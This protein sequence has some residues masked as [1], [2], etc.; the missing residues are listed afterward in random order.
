MTDRYPH[1]DELCCLAF[2]CERASRAQTVLAGAAVARAADAMCRARGMRP[3]TQRLSLV[4]RI[5]ALRAPDLAAALA[6]EGVPA[7]NARALAPHVDRALDRDALDALDPDGWMSITS[8]QGVPAAEHGVLLGLGTLVVEAAEALAAP[9]AGANAVMHLEPL[10][11]SPAGPW[12]GV[13]AAGAG[14][15]GMAESEA[16]KFLA[17][18]RDR[19]VVHRT[20]VRAWLPAQGATE[21]TVAVRTPAGL[22]LMFAPFVV[23]DTETLA[24]LDTVGLPDAALPAPVYRLPS[25][26]CQG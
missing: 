10:E 14:L 22:L 8:A 4:A 7:P 12:P 16:R 24:E 17:D 26:P 15:F 25:K 3:R 11:R 18:V 5:S 20:G 1:G 21:T 2:V 23:A 6:A 9:R 19:L 13:L